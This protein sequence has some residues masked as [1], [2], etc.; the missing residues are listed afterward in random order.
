MPSEEAAGYQLTQR[1]PLRESNPCREHKTARDNAKPLNLSRALRRR[2][3]MYISDQDQCISNH[4]R[5][6]QH[7]VSLKQ[8]L[9]PKLELAR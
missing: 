7:K 8:Q 1:R 4:D 6:H 2:G 3:Q 5:L 9:R